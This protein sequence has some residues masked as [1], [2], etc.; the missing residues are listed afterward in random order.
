MLRKFYFIVE[1]LVGL[2]LLAAIDLYVVK[3]SGA[4]VGVHPHPFWIVVLLLACRYGLVQGV[5][6]GGVAA[7]AYIVLA[8]RAGVVDFTTFSF[9]HGPYTLPF[10]FLLVGGLVGEIRSH[11]KKRYQRLQETFDATR[12]NHEHLTT[13]HQ[14]LTSSKWELEKRI[15]LQS[16]TMVSLFEQLTKLDQSDPQ[17]LYE[18]IPEILKEQLN[19]TCASVY[20]LRDNKLKLAVRKGWSS[21]GSLPDELDLAEGMVGEVVERKKM[22]AINRGTGTAEMAR[23]NGQRLIMCA[24]ILRKDESLVGVINVERIPFFDFTA[25]SVKVFET[26]AQW[27]S[28]AVEQAMQFQHFKDRNVADEI[29]GAYNYLYFQKRLSY[30]I[31]RAR[32]FQT[33]LSL[34]LLEIEHFEKMKASEQKNIL[35]VLNW[36]FSHIFRDTDIVAK[37]KRDSTFAIILPGQNSEDCDT[38]IDRIATEVHNY[39]L[40]PFETQEE[41]LQFRTGVSTLQLSEGSYETMVKTAEERLRMDEKLRETQMFDDIEYLL[42][43]MRQN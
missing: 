27:V 40:K 31:A 28:I 39:E 14:A 5:F 17:Q 19:V 6:A 23:F 35:T 21:T 15:A 20:L 3:K 1:T 43:I 8:A 32:R 29:T 18:K 13:E 2:V 41:V 42:N 7:L 34:L 25:N 36:I 33:A 24:P 12:E 11:Y 37:Y 26:L 9:P 22:V 4:F 38:I 30:E 10:F 16:T